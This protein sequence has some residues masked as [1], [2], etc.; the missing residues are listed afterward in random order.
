LRAEK[1][2]KSEIFMIFELQTV[3]SFCLGDE[4]FKTNLV[5]MSQRAHLINSI[6]L[7]KKFKK[8]FEKVKSCEPKS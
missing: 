6:R 3:A 4:N 5:P 8:R 1:V 7:K 2:E